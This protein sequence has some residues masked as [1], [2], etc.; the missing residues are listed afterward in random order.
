M[1]S[2][3]NYIR[4]S[5]EL[6]QQ[7]HSIRSRTKDPDHFADKIVRKIRKCKSEGTPFDITPANLFTK[8]ND[9]AGI[10]LLHLHT[11]QIVE[12]DKSLKAIFH[13]Q[14]LELVEG[15]SARTWDDEYRALFG[16]FNIETQNS[17]T[18]YTSVHYVVASKSSTTVTCEIQVRTLMEEVWGEV[19]HK[20]NYPHANEHIA[21]TEQ[22]K[23]LARVTSSATRLVDSIFAT[24][25]DLAKPLQKPEQ[26]A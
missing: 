5:T 24:V 3:L 9:L 1:K 8:I 16:S 15:P 20:V 13:E 10:R 4:E 25:A 6:E 18:M 22:I 23:A 14:P 21:C 11:R 12:I 26:Q 17:E 19:D 7:I 2:V